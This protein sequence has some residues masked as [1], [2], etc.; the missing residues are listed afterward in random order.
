VF[1]VQDSLFWV[2]FVA[3]ITACAA[4]IPVDGHSPALV[5]AGAVVYLLG[6]AAHAVIG[7]TAAQAH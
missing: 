3:A 7:R 4:T 6:L 5:V 2:A 1:T